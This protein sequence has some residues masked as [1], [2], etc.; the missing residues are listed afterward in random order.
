MTPRV[1]RWLS[2][3]LAGVMIF[4]LAGCSS[5]PDPSSNY[6]GGSYGGASPEPARQPQQGMST[7]TKIALLVG[8]AALAYMY[9]KNKNNKGHGP[10]GQYYRSKNGRVYYRD[11]QGKAHWV[12]PPAGGIRVPAHEAQQYERMASQF[13][14]APSQGGGRY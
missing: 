2:L 14:Y 13:E 5:G 8:A 10:Q 3:F 6:G 7:K 1:S 9:N 4:T 11:A 12:T